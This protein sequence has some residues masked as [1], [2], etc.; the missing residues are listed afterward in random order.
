[1]TDP[2]QDS[3]GKVPLKPFL[4][5]F[6]STLTDH[7]LREKYE[8]S[9]VGFVSLIK[10]LLAQNLITTDG[11]AKRREMAVQRDLAKQ[12]K[13]L[14]GL[15]IC[16]HCSHPSPHPFEKCPACG[17]EA[18]EP[19]SQEESLDDMSGSGDYA[20]IGADGE[21]VEVEIIEEVQE[22][23]SKETSRSEQKKESP[24]KQ[25]ARENGKVGQG[26]GKDKSAGK[27]K[28]SAFGE[29][30]SIFSKLKKK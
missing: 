5:D 28:G 12:S 14:S 7:E 18:S 20:Y 3:P 23:P 29:I 30:R 27:P 1:M 8:L 17:A 15:S 25:S 19:V 24:A 4:A 6:R 26:A 2:T 9:A 13:F 11:L 22:M 21:D 10:A 16:P